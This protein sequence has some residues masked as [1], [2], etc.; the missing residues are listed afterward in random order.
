MLFS[1]VGGSAS[2]VENTCSNIL[3]FG[4]I[5]RKIGRAVV[6]LEHPN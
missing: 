3:T 6:D 2:T 5:C 1:K 4:S